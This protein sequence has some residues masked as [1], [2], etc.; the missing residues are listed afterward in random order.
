MA[1]FTVATV[2]LA[3]NDSCEASSTDEGLVSWLQPV[4]QHYDCCR[5]RARW[6]LRTHAGYSDFPVEFFTAFTRDTHCADLAPRWVS[7]LVSR[8]SSLQLQC[9]ANLIPKWF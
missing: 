7:I 6:K 4:R 3:R 8:P 9:S 5:P 2:G 1:P